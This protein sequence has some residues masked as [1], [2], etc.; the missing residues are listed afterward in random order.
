MLSVF[1]NIVLGQWCG[2]FHCRSPAR[3]QSPTPCEYDIPWPNFLQ[4][5]FKRS[6]AKNADTYIQHMY[7]CN[8]WQ[9][10]LPVSVSQLICEKAVGLYL[11]FYSTR[12]WDCWCGEDKK[13]KKKKKVV[14][15]LIRFLKEM[16]SWNHTYL[17]ICYYYFFKL[18][19]H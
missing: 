18:T 7:S 15:M 13:W 8:L 16:N 11:L 14:Y 10:K 1:S 2:P 5:V 12:E 9:M 19:F 6:E 17:F 4:Y 3:E